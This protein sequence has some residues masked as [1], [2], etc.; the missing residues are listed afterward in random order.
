MSDLDL[1]IGNNKEY[2]VEVIQNNAIY[3]SKT[4]NY[5][6]SYHYLIAQKNYS[7]KKTLKNLG[8]QFSI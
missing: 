7:E 2:K 3:A 5:L 1:N 8:Q 4:K 6:L